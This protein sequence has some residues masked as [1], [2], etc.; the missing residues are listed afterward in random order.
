M[1]LCT[2]QASSQNLKLCGDFLIANLTFSFYQFLFISQIGP[3]DLVLFGCPNSSGHMFCPS[4][5]VAFSQTAWKLNLRMRMSRNNLCSIA[6]RLTGM[7]RNPVMRSA[8]TGCTN[9]AASGS[10]PPC[11]W[12]A[13]SRYQLSG[14][15]TGHWKP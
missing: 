12:L 8:K 7:L 13:Y 11:L 2:V 4:G 10:S 1:L 6:D 9:Q 14:S 15:S 5:A 3:L